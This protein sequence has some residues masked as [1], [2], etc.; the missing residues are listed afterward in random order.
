MAHAVSSEASAP[1]GT[2]L[3]GAADRAHA[4]VCC[5]R[6]ALELTPVSASTSEGFVLRF[7]RHGRWPCMFVDVVATVVGVQLRHHYVEYS[8]DD[9]SGVI[10]VMCRGHISLSVAE[11]SHESGSEAC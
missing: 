11:W 3:Q 5:V 7:Y 9:G 10:D 4:L 8:I 6:H 1:A 2:Q